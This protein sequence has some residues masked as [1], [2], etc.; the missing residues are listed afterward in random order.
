MID[1]RNLVVRYPDGTLAVD[2]FNLSVADGESVALVGANGAGKTS[3]LLSLVGILPSTGE[4]T[5]DGVT[6]DK[7]TVPILR[8]RVGLVFQNPDDQLFMPTVY[9][10]VAFGLRNRGMPEAE[11]R[12]RVADC[13]DR[14]R[15]RHLATRTPLKLSGGEKRMAALATV[16]VMEPSVML[17]DEPTAFLDPRSRRIFAHALRDLPQA[18]VIATHD[19]PFAARYCTRVVLIHE[20][21]VFAEG[22]PDRLLRDAATME[23]C[24]IEAID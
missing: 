8:Q 18:R 1:I 6:L 17:L 9:D 7:K 10:D 12:E 20:G 11:V 15:I 5:V 19:L 24:G 2:G 23:A 14:L 21:R 22:D 3:L 13:L 4:V 16:L